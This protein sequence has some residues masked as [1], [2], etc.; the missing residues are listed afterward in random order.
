M[1]IKFGILLHQD[2]SNENNPFTAQPRKPTKESVF[3]RSLCPVI[4]GMV[5]SRRP[6]ENESKDVETS[7]K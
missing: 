5:C 2:V 1:C 7:T 3:V 6:H 4:Q